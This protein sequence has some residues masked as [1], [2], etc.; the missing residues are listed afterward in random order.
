MEQRCLPVPCGAD[1]PRRGGRF[2]SVDGFLYVELLVG[3]VILGISLLA[4]VPM[5]VLSSQ[6]SAAAGDRTIAAMLTQQRAEEIRAL[7][8]AAVA[9]GT[10]LETV[11]V[12]QMQ[13]RLMS[14][15]EDDT[16]HGGMKR[17]T[18]SVT[19]LREYRIGTPGVVTVRFYHVP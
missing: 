5:F 12:H 1:A 2:P 11:I 16:P 14:V 10:T 7:D 3:M 8:Y 15:V 13:Y 6:T 4:L 17:V 9:P 18:V 19:P